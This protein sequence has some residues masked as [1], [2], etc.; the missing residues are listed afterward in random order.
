MGIKQTR[1]DDLD[2]SI[3]EGVETVTVSYDGSTYDIDLG[4][5][6]RAKLDDILKPFLE[7]GTRRSGLPTKAPTTKRPGL[8]KWAKDEGLVA[9]DYKGRIPNDVIEKYDASH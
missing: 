4:A 2:A 3:T 5:K 8:L 6:N 1:Y 7:A 9:P